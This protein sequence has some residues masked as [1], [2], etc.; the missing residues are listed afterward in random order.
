MASEKDESVR[1]LF[2]KSLAA[3]TDRIGATKGAGAA[4]AAFEQEVEILGKV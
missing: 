1:K 4:G 2:T 3:I